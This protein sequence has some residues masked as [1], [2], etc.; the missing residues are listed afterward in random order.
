M[1]QADKYI[2]VGDLKQLSPIIAD[3]ENES[4]FSKSI[5]ENINN[6]VAFDKLD[7]TY[8]MNK[9]IN[10]FPSKNFYNN[11]LESHQSISESKL[12]L[13]A[14]PSKHFEILD[15]NKPEILVTHDNNELSYQSDFEANLIL[16]FVEQFIKCGINPSD[17]AII[18]PYKAQVKL[19]KSKFS[20]PSQVDAL[21]INTIE[22]SQGQERD[23]VILSLVL[24]NPIEDKHRLDFFFNQN[25]M[26]VALTR[27]KKKRIVI[28]NKRLFHLTS[29]DPIFQLDLTSFTEFHNQSTVVHI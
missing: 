12:N 22:K 20:E 28:G 23:I 10:S 7:Y 6:N 16:E 25:R 11:E 19:L 9:W 5:L 8:R 14:L 26:N 18:T 21:F 17:I 15:E 24:S 2:F 3:K 1:A 4:I 29:S 13:T 27:A